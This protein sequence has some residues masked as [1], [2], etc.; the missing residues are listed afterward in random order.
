MMA[1]PKKRKRTTKRATKRATTK[2]APAKRR[3]KTNAVYHCVGKR[4]GCGGGADTHVSQAT[5]AP[6][7]RK[8]KSN[9]SAA[10]AK[11]S[12]FALV[13]NPKRHVKR[14]KRKSNPASSFSS[15]K[16]RRNPS[17]GSSATNAL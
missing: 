5:R 4:K 13:V 14:R 15:H 16:R 17:K 12:P 8:R 10:A 7:K 6:K 11:S 3:R 1:A 2:R 9:P